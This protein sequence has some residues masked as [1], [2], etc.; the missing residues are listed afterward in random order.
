MHT[1]DIGEAMAVIVVPTHH[2][3]GISGVDI[4][5]SD[6]STMDRASEAGLHHAKSGA[7]IVGD[8]G[9]GQRHSSRARLE[10]AGI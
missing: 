3:T 1:D 7:G 9:W 6:S 2:G 8:P 10:R 5:E 4:D